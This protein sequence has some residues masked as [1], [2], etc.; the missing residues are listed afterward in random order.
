MATPVAEPRITQ[1][2][3]STRGIAATPDPLATAETANQDKKQIPL[4]LSPRVAIRLSSDSQNALVH[5]IITEFCPRFTPA[6]MPIYVADSRKK[7]AHFNKRGLQKLGITVSDC[8]KMPNVV[9][10]FTDKNWLLLIEAVPSHGPVN[11]E[12]LAELKTLFTGSKAG[13]VFVTAFLDHHGFRKCLQEIAWQT[14]VWVAE[15]P[16]HMIHFNGHRFLRPY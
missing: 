15:D 13:L 6:G 14:E 10:H 7:W 3:A 16:D 2:Q 11:P 4:V 12:R 5:K 9:V 1:S 8:S